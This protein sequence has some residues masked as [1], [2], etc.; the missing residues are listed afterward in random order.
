[1][2]KYSLSHRCTRTVTTEWRSKDLYV[3][4][5][6]QNN[7]NLEMLSRNWLNTQLLNLASKGPP[8]KIW[9]A[10][11]LGV[12]RGSSI[13]YQL[14]LSYIY[15]FIPPINSRA[16]S[17]T[18]GAKVLPLKQHTNYQVV[19]AANITCL[20]CHG[21]SISCWLRVKWAEERRGQS[22]LWGRMHAPL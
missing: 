11:W 14:C 7:K 4:F 8:N 18:S 13:F 12:Q 17:T 15:L 21:N 1:M 10:S 20:C 19:V 22:Q 16:A 5:I 3:Q 9:C 6:M 2:W